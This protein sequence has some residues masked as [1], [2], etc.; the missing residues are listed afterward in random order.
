MELMEV[1]DAARQLGVSDR[2]L[3]KLVAS[4]QLVALGRGLVDARSVWQH[5]AQQ[6]VHRER[7][8]ATATAWAALD[9]LTGGSAEWLGKTQGSRLKAR[10]DGLSA[11]DLVS[12]TRNRATVHRFAAHR[13]VLKLLGARLVDAGA[14]GNRLGL[15]ARSDRVDGYLSLDDLATLMKEYALTPDLDGSVVVRAT[16]FDLAA[17]RR[18]AEQ[19][20][21]LAAVDLAGSLDTRERSAGMEAA[22][23]V[24]KQ[25]H[26]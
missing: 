18:I 12:R 24:L 3:R 17:V 26:G 21:L 11:S 14:T 23:G 25:W 20:P 1:Q 2:Q 22:A 6:G 13:S 15:T 8:W 19:S 5:Q 10:L 16:S 9:M 7:T 4:G